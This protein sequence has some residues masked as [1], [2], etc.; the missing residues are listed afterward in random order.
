VKKY[1][2]SAAVRVDCEEGPVN[3]PVNPEPSA[4]AE[5]RT[6]LHTIAELLHAKPRLGPREQGILAELVDEL[7]QALEKQASSPEEL[8][9]LARTTA[10]LVTAIQHERDAGLL[11]KARD[12]LDAAIV[13]V[14]S[15]APVLAGIARRLI[16]ALANLGI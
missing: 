6:H 2:S 15:E 3:E 16:A 1:R 4:V 5:V 14:E 13:A 9:R 8:A 10:E 11:G 7:S 12:R